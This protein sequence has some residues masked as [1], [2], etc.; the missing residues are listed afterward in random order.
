M[1][2]ERRKADRERMATSYTIKPYRH[3]KARPWS[4]RC[5]STDGYKTRE[6]RLAEAVGG[7]W[8]GRAGGYLMSQRQRERFEALVADPSKDASPITG[9][10]YDTPRDI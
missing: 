2:T 4:V 8:A 10:I 6:A 1:L 5:P 3:C 9:E 7:R